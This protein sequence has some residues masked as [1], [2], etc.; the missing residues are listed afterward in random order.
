[1]ALFQRSR[2][3]L[4]VDMGTALLSGM[5]WQEHAPSLTS[6]RG[7]TPIPKSL[8]WGFAKQQK[9]DIME[10]VRVPLTGKVS[11]DLIPALN[12]FFQKIDEALG[13]RDPATIT[14]GLAAPYYQGK[15]VWAH[16]S[17]AKPSPVSL[18]MIENLCEEKKDA[19]QKTLSE[20]EEIFGHDLLAIFLNGY[21]VGMHPQGRK[22]TQLDVAMRFSVWRSAL[23]KALSRLLEERF[24]HAVVRV[25]TFPV[26]YGALFRKIPHF[27]R[28]AAV[29]DIGGG[30]TE[31]SFFDD[32]ILEEVL[33]VPQ[34]SDLWLARIAEHERM[35]RD[36][37]IS[38]IG[39]SKKFDRV[40]AGYLGEWNTLLRPVIEAKMFAK[41]AR[42]FFLV[43]GGAL[44]PQISSS[45]S[46]L[47]QTFQLSSHA[48]PPDAFERADVHSLAVETFRDHFGNWP[49]SL[50]SFLDI[51]LIALAIGLHE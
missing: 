8:V 28:E 17:F 37:V 34:G 3:H 9:P 12:V 16:A 1:M 31:C 30:V 35:S 32:G 6:L 13:G 51:S 27:T 2:L 25:S 49:S 39:G 48:R 7:F 33:T 18:A 23:K 44:L 38:W 29:I 24:P 50:L 19:E 22:T 41:P 26:A 46:S 4:A 15:T 20:G 5:I 11:H 47:L 45:F 36:E 42:H 14:V 43:G 10:V 40:L 21:H